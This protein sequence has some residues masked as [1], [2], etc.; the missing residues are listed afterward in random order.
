MPYQ[1]EIFSILAALSWSA[2][3]ILFRVSGFQVAPLPLNLFKNSL[4]L[5]L[6]LPTFILLEVPVLGVGTGSDIVIL[7]ISGII[8]IAVA[9]TLFFYSLNLLGASLSAIVSS[10][11]SPSTVFFA[12]I[13]LGERITAWDYAGAILI[14]GAVLMTS[15]VTKSEKIEKRQF[16]QGVLIGALAMACMAVG[17]VLA[18]P[19][20]NKT[21]VLWSSL[22]RLLGGTVSLMMV[23]L[24]LPSRKNTW[25]VFVPQSSWRTSVPASCVGTYMA[26][27][28]W[29]AG[30]KF[31]QVS[32]AAILNQL[33]TIFT[34][35]LA[36]LFLKEAMTWNKTAAVL[37]A[38]AGAFL[39]IWF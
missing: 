30:M 8:G 7:V 27:I 5:L 11:Y 17:I 37:M 29:I 12:A 38:T 23:T 1:G 2:A 35:L 4:A 39:V 3:V 25:S 26:M 6:F 31:T 15:A 32:I 10:L 9:D 28:I 19:V 22:I 20:L 34:V 16:L 24:I 33:S 21:P 36:F 13:L 14:V 18:K